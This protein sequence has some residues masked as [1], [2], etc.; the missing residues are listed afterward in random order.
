MALLV[1]VS[2]LVRRNSELNVTMKTEVATDLLFCI[3]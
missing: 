2:A 3:V 1:A